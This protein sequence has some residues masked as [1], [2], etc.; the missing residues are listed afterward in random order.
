MKITFL[1]SLF[2]FLL[3]HF[4]FLFLYFFICFWCKL[5]RDIW[6]TIFFQNIIYC[7]VRR[8]SREIFLKVACYLLNTDK[9]IFSDQ[10]NN[11]LINF[12][13]IFLFLPE[14]ILLSKLQ[15]SLSFPF[16]KY[17][18]DFEAESINFS[19]SILYIEYPYQ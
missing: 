2:W 16:R 6:V 1:Q 15:F 9:L 14:P 11:F 4:T 18:F 5:R 8:S 13:I 7:S 12:W 10:I 3:H 17:R 19:L